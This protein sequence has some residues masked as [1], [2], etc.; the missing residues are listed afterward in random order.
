MLKLDHTKQFANAARVG[1]ALCA[2]AA[3]GGQAARAQGTAV[4]SFNQLTNPIKTDP[5][6]EGPLT[7]TNAFI[8]PQTF[9]VAAGTSNKLTF[10]AT[11]GVPNAGFQSA[12]ANS[13]VAPQFSDSAFG[14][15]PGDILE[16]T[17]YA[18]G[19]GNVATGPLLINFQ[20]PVAGF[21]LLAQ[22]FNQDFETFTLNIFDGMNATGTQLGSFTFGPVDNTSLRGNAVFVGALSKPGSLLIGSATLSSLSVATGGGGAPNNG[23][24]DFFFGPTQVQ[25]AGPVP[26][27]STFVSLGA[28]VL[29]FGGLILSARR[30]KNGGAPE[31]A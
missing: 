20:N 28:G 13:K 15:T 26:E 29:L 14:G 25:A 9:T 22:D 23:N 5:Y 12:L 3:L 7:G 24:N 6:P 17:T 30:R 19:N 8:V 4:T 2:L 27:A 18:G 10:T 21:G 31:A 1:V 16:N 11:N